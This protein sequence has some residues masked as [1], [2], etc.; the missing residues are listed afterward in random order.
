MLKNIT[1]YCIFSLFLFSNVLWAKEAVISGKALYTDNLP[2]PSDARLEVVLEDISLMDVTSVV[3]GESTVDPAGQIPIDFNITFD[4]EK[5]KL[6]NRYAVRAKVMQQEKLLYTTDTVNSVFEG[7]DD[8]RLNLIMKRVYKIPKSRTMEGMYR[9]MA[10]ASLFKECVTG[11]YYPVAFEADNMALEEAYLKETNGSEAY[12]K[13]S[14]KGKIVKR[15]TMEK[16]GQEEVLVVEKFI[17][18]DDKKDCTEQ[19]VNVPLTN[20]YW[21]LLSLYGKSVEVTKGEREAHILLKKGLNAVG[22]LKV[23]SGCNVF[24]GNYKIDAINIR[25]ETSPLD[26]EKKVCENTA[27]E[28][29]FLAAL[30]NVHYWSIKGEHLKL[31]DERDNVLAEFQAIFF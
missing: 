2:L 25:L 30:K 10:D 9:T 31:M 21:K 19:Q 18:L 13:V 14:V 3:L 6:G 16:T 15:G 24:K 4:D 7:N 27:L 26:I 17:R 12:I 11:K 23:V 22:T 5:V 1:M 20:N 8:S 28:E 29:K